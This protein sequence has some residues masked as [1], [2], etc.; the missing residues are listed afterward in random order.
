[1]TQYQY[2]LY[3]FIIVWRAVLLFIL[4]NVLFFFNFDGDFYFYTICLNKDLSS[5]FFALSI[6][7]ILFWL[8]LFFNL[9]FY[10]CLIS[11]IRFSLGLSISMAYFSNFYLDS[12]VL[13]PPPPFLCYFIEFEP[14]N[15]ILL[16]YFVLS[17]LTEGS[18]S[19]RILTY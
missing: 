18:A 16:F 4:F 7:F 14:G 6:K 13:S 9:F 15:F 1:M 3:F 19:S 2:H 10:L 11:D 17:D 12:D 8:F 5:L